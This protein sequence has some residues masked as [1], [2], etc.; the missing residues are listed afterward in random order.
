MADD[1]VLRGTLSHSRDAR[2]TQ[3]FHALE[4]DWRSRMETRT[5]VGLVAALVCAGLAASILGAR[6]DGTRPLIPSKPADVPQIDLPPPP[7]ALAPAPQAVTEVPKTQTPAT[8]T[9]PERGVQPSSIAALIADLRREV[10]PGFWGHTQGASLQAKGNTVIA[11]ATPDVLDAVGAWLDARRAPRD[12]ER[13][14]TSG[15]P[16]AAEELRAVLRGMLDRQVRLDGA[17]RLLRDDPNAALQLLAQVEKEEPDNARAKA[18]RVLAEDRNGGLAESAAL[19]PRRGSLAEWLLLWPSV[20][21]YAR[22]NELREKAG[23][24]GAVKLGLELAEV[25][26]RGSVTVKVQGVPLW[27]AVRRLQVEALVEITLDPEVGA[28]LETQTVT[29]DEVARSLDTV[30]DSLVAQLPA[31]HRWAANQR[32]IEI[33]LRADAAELPLRNRY[34]DVRD[35]LG[36]PSAAPAPAQPGAAPPMPPTYTEPPQK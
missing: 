1:E 19:P 11:R 7:P 8:E 10:E 23:P 17:A 18:L 34:F 24:A 32:S 28:R 12:P 6:G 31:G 36:A 14:R 15:D 33:T 20:N 2:V 9:P 16:A 27:V 3:P 5:V 30:L 13:E 29:L 4:G 25:L 21:T 22:L 26:R 35:L